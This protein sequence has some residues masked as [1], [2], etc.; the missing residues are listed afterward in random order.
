MVQDTAE[1]LTKLES[2]VAKVF[3]LYSQ[4]LWAVA[5]LNDGRRARE[6]DAPYNIWYNCIQV[7]Q[8]GRRILEGV[9]SL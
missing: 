5:Y 2:R 7:E 9:L 8:A 4:Q 3:Q 1:E 6:Q